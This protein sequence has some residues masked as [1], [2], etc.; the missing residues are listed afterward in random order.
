MHKTLFT[1][2]DRLNI[3]RAKHLSRDALVF[4]EMHV[5]YM[6]VSEHACRE[7][8]Y[9]VAKQL[10]ASVIKPRSFADD[11]LS[12]AGGSR[13]RLSLTVLSDIGNPDGFV[14]SGGSVSRW[15][16]VAGWR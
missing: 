12:G 15:R 16:S 6:S 1:Y 10:R 11:G 9:I 13:L 14:L 7:C 2:C 4:E 3:D 5:F 8:P